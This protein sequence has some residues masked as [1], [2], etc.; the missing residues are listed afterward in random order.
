MRNKAMVAGLVVC[1]AGCG[2]LRGKVV[3]QDRPVTPP[4]ELMQD[5]KHAPRPKGKTVGDLAGLVIAERGALDLCTADKG[6]LRAW[7]A[8]VAT[9]DKK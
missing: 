1:L 6:A 4:V 5:C 2:T 9:P 7:A 3:V 8:K